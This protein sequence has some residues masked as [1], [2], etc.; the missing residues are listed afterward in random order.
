LKLTEGIGIDRSETLEIQL[1]KKG[2]RCA[3]CS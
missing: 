2:F 3:L 1:S